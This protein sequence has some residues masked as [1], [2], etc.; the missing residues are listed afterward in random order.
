MP[1]DLHSIKDILDIILTSILAIATVFLAI[2]TCKLV[3]EARRARRAQVQ[4]Y[5]SVH[6]EQAETDPTLL[7]IIV[8]NIGPGIAYD[9]TFDIKQDILGDYESGVTKIGL[10]GLFKVGMKFCPPEYFKKYFLIETSE[11]HDK[12]MEE[13]LILTASYKNLYRKISSEI[14]YLKLKEQQMTSSITPSDTHIGR[15]AETLK[16]IKEILKRE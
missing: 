3:A 11:N 4:P 5:I 13:E 16:E 14:F 12:K 8:Q 9:L 1:C 6:L 2:Y 7:F 10:R 15:I